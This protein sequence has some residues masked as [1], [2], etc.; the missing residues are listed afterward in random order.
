MDDQ[1]ILLEVPASLS[2]P[3]LVSWH[4]PTHAVVSLPNSRHHLYMSHREILNVW[5]PDGT[6][7]RREVIYPSDRPNNLQ[8]SSKCT[9]ISTTIQYYLDARN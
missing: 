7:L 2:S 8:I 9:Q 4:V 6:Q 1:S 5:G 3:R